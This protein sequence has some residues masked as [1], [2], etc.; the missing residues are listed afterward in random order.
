MSQVLS[1]KKLVG[2]MER[3]SNVPDADMVEMYQ[4]MTRYYDGMQLDR[5]EKDFR[6]KDYIILLKESS[7]HDIIGFSTFQMINKNI[8]GIAHSVLFSG[9]T[10]VDENFWGQLEL[11]RIWLEFVVSYQ[12]ENPQVQLYWFLICK[13]YKTYRFLPTYFYDFYPCYKNPELRAEKKVLDTFAK[14]KF[15]DDYN[16]QTNIIHY[17]HQKDRLKPGIADID[18][19]RLRNPHVRYFSK[20]NPNWSRG[21]ELACIVKIE[22]KNFKSF[23]H[24]LIK[25]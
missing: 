19:G 3:V 22:P 5:F 11:P 17:R 18:S 4:L 24:K 20:K 13:G 9:D 8:D 6:E 7:N 16:P 15:G 14:I 1:E 25:K 21:D 23:V 10:I 2:S 12:Q